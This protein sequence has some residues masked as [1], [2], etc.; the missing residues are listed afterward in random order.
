MEVQ[1]RGSLRQ[2]LEEFGVVGEGRSLAARLGI[3]STLDTELT[4]PEGGGFCGFLLQQL[5]A[6]P[7]GARRTG[8]AAERT[9]T[10]VLN[11][12]VREVQIAVHHIADHLACERAA[13]RIG[14]RLQ[15]GC[16]GASQKGMRRPDGLEAPWVQANG[17]LKLLLPLR[18][19][20]R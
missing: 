12:V 19:P 7:I 4:R 20:G 1:T 13:Q 15:R 17:C 9:K 11:A 8:I 18:G 6:V 14:L 10:A 5:K 3:K 2:N 16:V